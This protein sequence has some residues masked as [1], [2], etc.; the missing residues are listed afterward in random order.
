[1]RLRSWLPVSLAAVTGLGVTAARGQT[2]PVPS[3]QESLQIQ[4]PSSPEISPDG[5]WVVY[6]VRETDWKQDAYVTHLWLANT[7]DG[8]RFQLTRG[9]QSSGAAR[10]SPD[11]RWIAFA[12]ERPADADA[13]PATKGEAGAEASPKPAPRQLWLIS[14][15][16]GEAWQLTRHLT[17]VADFRWSPDGQRIAFSAAAEASPAAKQRKKRYGDF[18]VF[19]HDFTQTQ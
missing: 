13:K 17:N 5:A 1:M 8:R 9:A 6:G 3:F 7:R 11:S 12:A 10:W 4:S 2:R 19:E 16:G 18:A 15:S 14:P